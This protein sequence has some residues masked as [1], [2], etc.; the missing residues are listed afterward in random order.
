MGI[1]PDKG[2]EGK[3]GKTNRNI[4]AKVLQLANALK[5]FENVSGF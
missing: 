5:D 4:H 3:K 2:S 1:N